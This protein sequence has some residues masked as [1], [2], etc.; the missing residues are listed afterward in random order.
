MPLGNQVHAELVDRR[1]FADAGHTGNANTPGVA[2]RRK[3]CLQEILCQLLIIWPR[4]LDQRDR[5]R[6]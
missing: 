1:R 6:Q 3:E 4:A 5:A 2:G